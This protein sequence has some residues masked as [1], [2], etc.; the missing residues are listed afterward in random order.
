MFVFI[1]RRL[2]ALGDLSL[3]LV[4]S[5]RSG[6]FVTCFLSAHYRQ[7]LFHYYDGRY[8]SSGV[9]FSI[10]RR[11]RV[12]NATQLSWV[13]RADSRARNNETQTTCDDLGYRKRAALETES[14]MSASSAAGLLSGHFNLFHCANAMVDAVSKF[15]PIVWIVIRFVGMNRYQILLMDMLT[16]W[17]ICCCCCSHLHA[18]DL[19]CELTTHIGFNEL[20]NHLAEIL[21]YDVC[22]II[23]IE[24]YSPT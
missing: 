22:A 23:Y 14:L 12:V 7:L 2:R 20:R 13:A 21:C 1:S 16:T 15:L 24:L 18:A 10:K 4:V 19:L 5:C 3:W 6:L 8:R 17:F 11:R 9:S